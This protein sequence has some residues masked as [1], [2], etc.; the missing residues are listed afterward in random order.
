[1]CVL[2]LTTSP[3]WWK[4]ARNKVLAA[5]KN[6]KSKLNSVNEKEKKKCFI[7]SDL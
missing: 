2:S 3:A 5:Q 6:K 1:M 4:A 7:L